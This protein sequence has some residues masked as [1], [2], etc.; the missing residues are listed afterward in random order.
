MTEKNSLDIQE[1]LKNL[2]HRFPFLLVDRVISYEADKSILAYK[3]ISYNEHYFQ[4]H[5]PDKAVMPGVLMVEALA[6]AAGILAY[7]STEWDPQSSLFYLGTINEIKYRRMV[8]PGDRL[9]LNVEVI[10]RR[11]QVWKFSCKASVDDEDACTIAEMTCIE[12]AVN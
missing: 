4:G 8:V 10:K 11:K 5:F 1:I 12:G 6:Q 7:K 2:P 3:N 9:T